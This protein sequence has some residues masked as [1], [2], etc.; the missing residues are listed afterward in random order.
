VL[1]ATRPHNVEL[2]QK[3]RP[4]LWVSVE[5]GGRDVSSTMVGMRQ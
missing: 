4:R 3:K 1:D 2:D 5:Q